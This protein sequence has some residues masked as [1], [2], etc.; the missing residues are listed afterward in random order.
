MKLASLFTLSSIAF[1]SVLFAEDIIK[2]QYVVN[3][4]LVLSNNQVFDVK[5]D[6][7]I[8]IFNIGDEISIDLQDEGYYLLQNSAGRKATCN[9]F[10]DV[11]GKP[12]LVTKVLDGMVLLSNADLYVLN[13]NIE[14]DELAIRTPVVIVNTPT[15]EV[16]I[17]LQSGTSQYVIPF[18]KIEWG[19]IVDEVVGHKD[20]VI[21]LKKTG[22][23]K[24]FSN[25]LGLNYFWQIGD[26]VYV[27]K[28][29]E[30]YVIGVTPP[31]E[32]YL[33]YNVTQ[34]RVSISLY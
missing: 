5:N 28:V 23:F 1:F 10:G 4:Q 13:N 20:D 6:S 32:L 25:R 22:D 16:M 9:F 14:Q 27:K 7:E 29:I 8:S 34:G 30:S 17:D 2:V 12:C 31:T 19:K 11:E 18:G 3:D 33:L 24:A 15:S 26:K 21:Q